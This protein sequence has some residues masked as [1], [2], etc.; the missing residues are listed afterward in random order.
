M[1]VLGIALIDFKEL[2]IK[3]IFTIKNITIMKRILL[4]MLCS[5]FVFSM[6]FAQGAKKDT[7]ETVTFYVKDMDCAGCAQKVEK[8]IAFEK[9]VTDLKCDLS[10]RTVQV[11]FSN[12]KTTEKKL[13]DAFKKIGMEAE[14]KVEPEKPAKST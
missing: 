11:T 8:N 13:I 12:D 9:G 4:I 5:V 3:K 7:K 6:A 2:R 14:R 1:Q 10:K